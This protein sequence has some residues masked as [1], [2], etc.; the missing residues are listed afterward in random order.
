NV[1][2]VQTCAL[3]I[4]SLPAAAIQA[5]PETY[6]GLVEVGVGL[7]PGGGGTKELY[8]KMLRNMPKDVDFDLMQVAN[9]VFEKIAMAKV[10]TSA[11]EARENGFLDRQDG[12]SVNTDHL[13][14]D[15]K[16][17]VLTLAEAGYRAKRCENIHV[18]GYA[19]YAAMLL[20]EK[21]LLLGGYASDHDVNIG[22][23]LAYVWSG[24]RI[25]E[26]S[27]IDEQVMLDLERE[28]LLSLVG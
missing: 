5:S 17:K 16:Q 26:G 18:K 10:S 13:L 22:E 14:Y 23:N 28:A 2:G 20:D 3:P 21:T 19:E 27:L 12:I 25:K 1:T 9:N 8:L 4:F 15:A 11:A 24:G 6:M 7:I